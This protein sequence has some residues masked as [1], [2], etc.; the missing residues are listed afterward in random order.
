MK[1]LVNF[2]VLILGLVLTAQARAT[3]LKLD[4][5]TAVIDYGTT[6]VVQ[7]TTAGVAV[8][9][10]VYNYSGMCDSQ[11]KQT[12]M[13]KGS[14]VLH[15]SIQHVSNNYTFLGLSSCSSLL[16]VPVLSTA[17]SATT[18]VRTSFGNGGANA[19]NLDVQITGRNQGH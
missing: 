19:C 16:P 13:N 2:S 7:G 8:Q 1:R 9:A 11:I 5:V 4:K 18:C 15:G 12:V 6:L 10:I 14:L 3:A 17:S